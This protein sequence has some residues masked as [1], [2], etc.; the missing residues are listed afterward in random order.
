M[1]SISKI[2]S[3]IL[4]SLS[5]LL[6]CY[7]FYRSEILHSGDLFSYYKKYYIT[8]FLFIS[9]SVVSFFVPSKL[10][11]NIFTVFISSLI[12]L[13][14]IEG[15]LLIKNNLDKKQEQENKYTLY[16]NNTGKDYDKRTKFQIYQ[17]LKKEDPKIAAGMWPVGFLNEVNLNLLPL[18][19]LPNRKVIHCNENGYYSIYQ[20]DRYG[21][22][23]PD[24]EWEKNEIEFFLV[25]DSFANGACVNEPDTISGNLKKL[26]N[27]PNGILSLG[28]SSN[29]PLI[30]YATLRE[31][32]SIKKVKR[33]LWINYADNDLKDLKLELQNKI[34]VNYLKDK[35]FSQNLISKEKALE[36]LLLKRLQRVELLSTES[37]KLKQRVKLINFLKLNYLRNKILSGLMREF[38]LPTAEF[39]NILKLSNEFANQNNSKFYFVYL[40]RYNRYLE[41]RNDKIFTNYKK[42]IKIVESLNIPIIDIHKE[43]FEKHED[44]LSLF[45]FRKVGH[46]NELGYQLVAEKIFNKIKELEK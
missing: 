17:D 30:E 46:Y 9:F 2:I 31:Y 38:S 3:I 42:I 15:Y 29:G 11:I 13:Y 32:L 27:S 22:N 35:N 45:P 4:L 7:V 39:K 20:S 33:V 36:K 10:K 16:K 41:T 25:G 14:L 43:L 8:A 24:I 23:N 28:Q 18:S 12:G 26:N 6:L 1:K 37:T 40:P 19:G 34:L 21:F 5:I 44:P